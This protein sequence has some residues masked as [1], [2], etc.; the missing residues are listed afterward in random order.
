[1]NTTIFLNST[2]SIQYVLR[3]EGQST[4][5]DLDSYDGSKYAFHLNA[6]ASKN[7]VIDWP[8]NPR[9]YLADLRV[10]GT[11]STAADFLYWRQT[12]IIVQRVFLDYI[13]YGF[14]ADDY[15][16]RVALRDIDWRN[17]RSGGQLL[18]L[19]QGDAFLLDGANIYP[20]N[21]PG[22][23]LTFS[24][25]FK[26]SRVIGGI[27][28]I[29]DCQGGV[30]EN[31]H[32]ETGGELKI[33][34]CTITVRDNYFSNVDK[35]NGYVILVDNG[36]SSVWHSKNQ[37]LLEHNIFSSYISSAGQSRDEDVRLVLGNRDV[38]VFRDNC[39]NISL[40]NEFRTENVGI[41]VR[42]TDSQLD[43]ALKKH[44][45]RLAGDVVISRENG[46]WRVWSPQAWEVK[47]CSAPSMYWAGESSKPSNLPQGTYYYRAAYY[48]EVG[49]TNGSAEWNVTTSVDNK[50]VAFDISV[51]SAY[52]ILR[53]WR[54]TSSGTYDRYADVPVCGC[55]V[56]LFDLGDTLSGYS[57]ITTDVPS[58]PSDNTLMD[59]IITSQGKRQF[60]ASAA[61]S[62]SEFEG[63]KGDIVW[64]TGPSAGGTPGWICVTAGNPGTWKA[65]AN[66]AN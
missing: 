7:R 30:F 18:Y 20:H 65:M 63:Q 40:T 12:G 52:G 62:S 16:D 3:G 11:N 41:Y 28:T 25:G 17:P 39:G 59:G 32:L 42:S 45:G 56:E 26:V 9:L 58:V 6:D 64:N 55:Q 4:I 23:L 37:V 53:I 49:H 33:G 35:P 21:S 29:R 36:I 34:N 31:C 5:L 27:H 38:I 50:A 14:Y 15:C 24:G 51:G 43:A 46:E 47:Q 13:R 2:A 54:G 60:W 10:V 48:N 8:H 1:I 44:M 22:L 61:P 57:W 66:L 19:R